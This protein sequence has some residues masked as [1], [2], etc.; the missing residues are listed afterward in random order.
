MRVITIR[1]EIMYSRGA[2]DN[3]IILWD[4]RTGEEICRKENAHEWNVS[5]IAVAPDQ[6][7]IVTCDS[8]STTVKMWDPNDNL[9]ELAEL[10][11]HDG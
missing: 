2:R 10:K 9:K 8:S 11:G 4:V 5:K 1:M 7:F 6:F 3:T